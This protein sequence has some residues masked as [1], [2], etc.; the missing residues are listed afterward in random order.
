MTPDV[1]H[2]LVGAVLIGWLGLMLILAGL[3]AMR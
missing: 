2:G 3:E 1:L